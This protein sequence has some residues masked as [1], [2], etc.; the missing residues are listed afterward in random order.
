MNKRFEK[1]LKGIPQSIPPIWFM[2]QAGRYHSH[3]QNLRRKHSFEE[4]CKNPELAAEVAC[5]PINDFDY[6]IAILFSDILFP[7]ELLGLKLSY[8]PG[9]TFENYLT[10]YHAN[11][12]LEESQVEEK[13]GFQSRALELTRMF[14]PEN[15]SLVGFVGG[16]WTILS[17]GMNI[18]NETTFKINNEDTFI[19]KL[20]YDVL[21]PMLRK[22]IQMQ[23]DAG[24]ELVYIFDTNS[25][26]MKGNYYLDV[27]MERMKYDLFFEFSSQLVYFSKNKRF[28]HQNI[29]HLN[30]Y[31]LAGVVYPDGEGFNNF[32]KLEKPFFVQGN[33]SPDSLLKNH[34]SYL[35]DFEKFV[36]NMKHFTKK[37]RKGWLCSL[38][39]GVLPK[40]PEANVQHFVREIR[41]T[42][43]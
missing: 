37:D 10:K 42:F 39:H 1:L 7:L 34:S 23:L 35:I 3:Y 18:K 5:G 13:L 16:P 32:L 4:L 24:A 22:N 26:Q 11:M 8:K 25:I 28:Y 15:K 27:Y 12:Q 40:T 2:R 29:E 20:L 14:L 30:S 43:S 9:P 6:D 31:D 36:Q 21:F 19:E 41:N 38:S 17:Y 33:F